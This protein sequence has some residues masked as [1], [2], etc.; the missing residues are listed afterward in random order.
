MTTLAPV[1]RRRDSPTSAFRSDIQALR[2]LAVGAVLVYHLWPDLLTGGFVGVDVFFV[3][4]GF[5]ITTHLL[6]E[7]ARTRRIDVP[8]FW[9]RRAKRLLPAALIV[10]AAST[11]VRNGSVTTDR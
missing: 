6:S 11:G 4:S 5:L 10:L 8:R 1:R 2:A 9:A 7:V 3:I